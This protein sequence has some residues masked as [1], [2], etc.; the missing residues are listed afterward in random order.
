MTV[1]SRMTVIP[2]ERPVAFT[3]LYQWI[4]AVDG[5]DRLTVE[6]G[7]EVLNA[8]ESGIWHEDVDRQREKYLDQHGYQPPWS[9]RSSATFFTW[10]QGRA[11]ADGH[12]MA[13]SRSY[14]QYLRNAA[15]MHR[16]VSKQIETTVAISLPPT[17]R[18]WRP[19]TKFLTGGTM[20]AKAHDGPVW[21]VELVQAVEL[22]VEIAQE[23]GKP[24]FTAG[25]A[26]KAKGEVWRTAPRI[27]QWVDQ[28]NKPKNDESKRDV[29]MRL[30]HT[31]QRHLENLLNKCRPQD[32]E[33]LRDWFM[34]E[35]HK[36]LAS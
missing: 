25:V 6:A 36:V 18:A 27:R 20:G 8:Y 22:A 2:L 33:K 23:E 19:L 7:Y 29:S 5:A 26:A 35:V 15:E 9:A 11:L 24:E 16:Y 12:P 13:Q 30:V 34:T 28:P 4:D 32:L 21:D 31:E 14:F 17:E 1:V 3:A 10:L